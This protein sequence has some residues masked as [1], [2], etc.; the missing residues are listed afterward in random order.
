MSEPRDGGGVAGVPCGALVVPVVAGGGEPASGS[1]CAKT[2]RSAKRK[3]TDK[4][5]TNKNV[6]PARRESA[7]AWPSIVRAF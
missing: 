7:R 2:L 6:R 5:A 3:G 1:L 4:Q